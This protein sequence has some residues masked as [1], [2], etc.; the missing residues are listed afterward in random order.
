MTENRRFKQRVRARAHKTG[1]SYT[2]ALQHFRAEDAGKPASRRLRIAAAQVAS[3]TDPG[4]TEVIRRAGSTVRDL[5]TEAHRRE[6]ALIHFGEGTLCAPGKRHMSSDPEKITD[7]DWSRFDWACQSRELSLIADHAAALGLWTV[8]GAVHRLTSPHRPH[9][10]LYVIDAKGQVSCR[11]DER[12][13]SFTKQSHM[14]SPGSRPVTFSVDGVRFGCALGMESV[15]P[16]VFLEYERA[17]VDCVLFSSHGA[18]SAFSLQ[19]QAHASANS[20]WV[21]YATSCTE[22]AAGAQSGIAGVKGTWIARCADS[23]EP[24]I[25]L[26]DI[27]TGAEN[28]ARPWRR[29]ARANFR[30]NPP[31]DDPR[32][33]DN[34]F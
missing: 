9:N 34:T 16:E 19:V 26:A 1:E 13:L 21:S 31:L 5:M 23:A 28:L 32:A 2:T 22:N 8:I 7:S 10:S 4:D 12:M 27:D 14:Y 17:E 15:Y 3:P 11:Y 33:S 6:A 18:S 29:T 30:N 20:L 25:A 24:A